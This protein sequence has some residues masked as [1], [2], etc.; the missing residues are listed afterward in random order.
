MNELKENT[1]FRTRKLKEINQITQYEWYGVDG[2]HAN[3]S[4]LSVGDVMG[5]EQ[6]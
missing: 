1:Q 2:L 4:E 5:L 6:Y 3:V